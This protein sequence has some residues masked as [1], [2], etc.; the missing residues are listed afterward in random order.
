LRGVVTEDVTGPGTIAAEP[1]CNKFAV[2]IVGVDRCN[3]QAADGRCEQPLDQG[4]GRAGDVGL[5]G[6]G[7][8]GAVSE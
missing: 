3:L 1:R 5:H 6:L 7:H 8:S 2:P 4:I